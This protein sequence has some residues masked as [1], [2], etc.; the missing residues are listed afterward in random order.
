[1]M[2]LRER[3]RCQW[4]YDGGGYGGGLK[5]RYIVQIA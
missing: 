4:L 1:M 5:K 3:C 2:G